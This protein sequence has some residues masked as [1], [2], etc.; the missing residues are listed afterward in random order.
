MNE[1]SSQAAGQSGDLASVCSELS[2]RAVLPTGREETRLD[3]GD[4]EQKCFTLNGEG[5]EP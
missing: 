2:V 1:E 5:S 4:L 3:P